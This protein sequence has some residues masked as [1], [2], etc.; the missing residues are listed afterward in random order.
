MQLSPANNQLY[1]QTAPGIIKSLLI[2]TLLIVCPIP[3]KVDD[4]LSHK[5]LGLIPLFGKYP[6][7]LCFWELNERINATFMSV[8]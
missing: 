5:N 1:L 4:F 7:L 3:L 6:Y 8:C 2:I